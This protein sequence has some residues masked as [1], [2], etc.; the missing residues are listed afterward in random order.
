MKPHLD[1]RHRSD[2]EQVLIE[3]NRTEFMST[4]AEREET[5]GCFHSLR[6]V[7][8]VPSQWCHA[9]IKVNTETQAEK[10]CS[11]TAFQSMKCKT[12]RNNLD[13]MRNV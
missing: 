1:Q 4:R 11:D 5:A 9:G 13:L 7:C 10:N 12:E 3:N 8:D 6:S 2:G